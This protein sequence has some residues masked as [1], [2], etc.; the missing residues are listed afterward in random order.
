MS[1]QWVQDVL[2]FKMPDEEG[3][4]EVVVRWDDAEVRSIVL[5]DDGLG[6]FVPHGSASEFGVQLNEAGLAWVAEQK[7]LAEDEALADL[8]E[9]WEAE[10][11]RAAGLDD[12]FYPEQDD[13]DVD[14]DY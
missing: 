10:Q 12:A 7:A 9:E 5:T 4:D 14:E 13:P 8:R 2:P 1:Q 11:R 3:A 6:S